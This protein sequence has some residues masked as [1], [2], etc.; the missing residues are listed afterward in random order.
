MQVASPL[1]PRADRQATCMPTAH[2]LLV[3]LQLL[4][5]RYRLHAHLHDAIMSIVALG[6]TAAVLAKPLS[7]NR[8]QL[9]VPQ[10][11]LD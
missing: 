1:G 7:L 5:P 11:Y 4:F 8:H 6:R 2:L 9:V 3:L 10:G